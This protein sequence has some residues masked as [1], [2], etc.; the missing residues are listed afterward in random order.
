MSLQS[1][2]LLAALVRCSSMVRI[3]AGEQ[4]SRHRNRLSIQDHHRRRAGERLLGWNSMVAVAV[5]GHL[6]SEEQSQRI[7]GHLQ[8]FFSGRVGQSLSQLGTAL[9]QDQT[10]L[11][12]SSLAVQVR[13]ATEPLQHFT[14]LESV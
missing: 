1:V 9:L 14:T 3:N 7:V 5:V 4:T 6:V 2:Q 13:S 11:L 10:E 12:G 8:H